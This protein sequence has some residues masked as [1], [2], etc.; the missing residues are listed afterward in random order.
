MKQKFLRLFL[1][2]S[3]LAASNCRLQAQSLLTVDKVVMDSIRVAVN[4]LYNFQFEQSTKSLA[5]FKKKY[6]GHPGFLLLNCIRN[7]WKF[8]PIGSNASEYRQYKNELSQ[9]VSLSEK[10]MKKHPGSPEPGYYFMTANLLLARHHSE[11]GEYISAVN[12]TRKAF[13][14]I[15]KGFRLKEKF[16][17]FYFSTG[18]YNY[19][20]VAFPEHHPVYS[21]FTYFFPDGN[22][23]QGLKELAT[24]G[25][26]SYFSSA[27]ARIFLC[28][29]YLRDYYNIPKAF[30]LASLLHRLYPD[31]WVVSILY[32][33][34]LAE[35]GKFQEAAPLIRMLQGRNEHAALLA[36]FYLQGL[37]ERKAGKNDAAKWNFQKALMYG[38]SKDRL[39]TGHIGLTYNELAKIALSENDRDLA[40]KYFDLAGEN[41][42]YKKVK[43]DTKAA[44]F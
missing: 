42:R 39:T 11:D 9:V 44:G 6:G 26:K 33:E 30:D 5:G 24:A 27:E 31:N 7:Y 14:Q 37:A 36:G 25:Q 8:L 19:Y 18:L 3:V 1:L 15:K 38:K 23:E 22:K 17:D 13:A 32:A 21:P 12:E 41:C 20:R 35:T 10:M 16:P 43:D 4:H 29:I 34:T 28:N 2:F 40:G